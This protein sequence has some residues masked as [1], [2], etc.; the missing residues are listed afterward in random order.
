M[1]LVGVLKSVVALALITVSVHTRAEEP[2]Q[3]VSKTMYLVVYDRG[4]AWVGNTLAEQ[5]LDAHGKYMLDLYEKG[6]LKF[7]GP[8]LDDSGGAV[9]LEAADETSVQALVA[10]DPAVK[11]GTFV[12]KIRPWA[13]Q[14]WD[15]YLQ[16]RRERE[17]AAR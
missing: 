12:S 10:N 9:V 11:Q 17:K 5:K 7:A 16:K 3:T 8:F 6:A 13:L 4:P 15:V 14:P 2:V 1:R